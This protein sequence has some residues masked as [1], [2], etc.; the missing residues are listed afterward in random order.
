ME[1]FNSLLTLSNSL[2]ASIL[3]RIPLDPKYYRPLFPNT[4]TLN[5]VY[6]L[7]SQGVFPSLSD[8][9]PAFTYCVI[10]SIVRFV[11]QGY[12][13]KVGYYLLRI[14]PLYSLS[15]IDLYIRIFSLLLNGVCRSKSQNSQVLKKSIQHFHTNQN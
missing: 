10:L 8:L 12:L 13:M 4:V 7:K 1:I 11:L 6:S 5:D 14:V 15:L 9:A 2:F 3:S